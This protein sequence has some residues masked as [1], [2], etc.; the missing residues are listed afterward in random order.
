M[1]KYKIQ[2]YVIYETYEM[3]VFRIDLT[4]NERQLLRNGICNW[5]EAIVKTCVQIGTPAELYDITSDQADANLWDEAILI[6]EEEW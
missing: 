2:V 1:S 6:N 3:Y 4:T 5:P